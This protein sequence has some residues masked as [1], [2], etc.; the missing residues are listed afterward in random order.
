MGK[1]VVSEDGY[2]EWDGEKDMLNKANHGLLF[3][4]ILPAFE[5][6][7]LLEFYDGAHSTHE[8]TRFKGLAELQDFIVLYLSYTERPGGRTRIISVRPPNQ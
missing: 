2:F 8:E 4:E 7:Y 6:P 5:D 1:T 3:S